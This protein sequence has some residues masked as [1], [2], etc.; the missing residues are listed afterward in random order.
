L[1]ED[2]TSRATTQVIHDSIRE[3]ER[4]REA[5]KLQI[6]RVIR[7]M[8]LHLPNFLLFFFPLFTHKAKLMIFL[9]SHFSPH[10]RLK[11]KAEEKL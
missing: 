1:L 11:V 7:P 4:R 2:A 6:K 5:G 10:R 3:S 8:L 9:D